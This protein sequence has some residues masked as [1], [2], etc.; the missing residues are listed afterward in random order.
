IDAAKTVH[1]DYY[2]TQGQPQFVWPP[3]FALARA[4]ADQLERSKGLSSGRL[5]A[6]RQALAAAESA[7][8]TQRRDALTSLAAQLDA[9]ARASSDGGKVQ[10]LAKAVRDLAATTS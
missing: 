2:N 6:V 5:S 10:L 8:G 3:S 1:F 9:D 4:Y 7:S